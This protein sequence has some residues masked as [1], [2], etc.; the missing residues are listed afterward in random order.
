[1]MTRVNEVLAWGS[2]MVAIKRCISVSPGMMP[3]RAE[4]LDETLR[5]ALAQ[6]AC[7]CL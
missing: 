4:Q 3:H 5:S 2:V 7:C 6:R 1:M